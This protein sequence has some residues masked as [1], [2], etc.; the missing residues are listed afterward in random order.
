MMA[1]KIQQLMLEKGLKKKDFAER[2][3]WTSSNLYNKMRRD[4]FS[5]SELKTMADALNC[6]LDI[7]FVS[8]ER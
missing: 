6:D 4:D 3:G 2:C 5:E 7:K 1:I 8:K